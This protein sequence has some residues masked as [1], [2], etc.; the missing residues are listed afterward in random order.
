MHLVSFKL[1]VLVIMALSIISLNVN[2]LRESS[3]RD[4]LL[5]WL[6]SLPVTVDVVSLQET[7]CTSDVECHTWFSSSGLSLVLSPGTRHSG[8]CIVLY[9]PV[10]KLVN[11]WCEVP[12][13]SLLCE[14]SFY[15]STFHVL[16]LYALSYNPARD[17]FFNCISDTVDTSIPTV[18]CG[19]FDTVFDR[20]FHRFGSFADD[21]SRESTVALGCLFDSCCVIDF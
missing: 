7:H 5:Q 17:L 13:R 11:F 16:C 12:G 1:P 15:Y 20:T 4:G 2:G 21:V 8:G 10:L 14:F 3:K 6:Q 19:D 9:R 18:L